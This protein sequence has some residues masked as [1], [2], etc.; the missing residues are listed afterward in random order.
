LRISNQDM[1][2]NGFILT[3]LFPDVVEVGRFLPRAASLFAR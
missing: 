3:F 1:E 2:I